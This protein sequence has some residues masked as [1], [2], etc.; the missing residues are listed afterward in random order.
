[1]GIVIR[2][3]LK[4]TF[5]N[6][7]GVILGI[8]IQFY[9]V[10]KYLEPQVYG[11]TQ[12]IYQAA[13]LFATFALLGSGSSGMRYF[14]YFRDEKTRD[15][16]FLYYFMM[17]PALGC[18]IFVPLYIVLKPAIA[19]Y[20]AT[21][22]PEFVDYYYYVIPFIV[23]LCFWFW[24]ENYANINMRIAIPKTVREILMRLLMLGCY[25]AYG[26]GYLDVQ[27][28]ILSFA[29][30][31]A[32]C[33]L[34][35]GSYALKIGSSTT[36]HRD[37][38]VLTPEVKRDFLNYTFIVLI[39]SLVNVVYQL[40]IFMLSGEKGLYDAGIYS[41]MIFFAN[42]VNMPA[43]SITA[44][45]APG[46]A[47]AM[48]RNDTATASALFKQVS[49]HQLMA[50]AITLLVIWI[51][52]DNIFEIMP[53]GDKFSAGRYAM[54]LLG[55]SQ[56]VYCTLNFGG[57]IISYSKYYYWTLFVTVLLI[58]LTITTNKIFIPMWGLAGA[59]FATLL[60][61][62]I[63]YS[64]QQVIIQFKI[65]ANPFTWSHLRLLLIIG[66]L[67]G[68]NF[69]IPSFREVSPWLDILVR[70]AAMGLG[71]VLLLYAF[72]VSVQVNGIID[73]YIL[74]KGR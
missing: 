69:L 55:L 46:V 15:H 41:M 73:Y 40:D 57:S 1:M 17:L 58:F 38:S 59:A 53:N 21:K 25:L 56:V 54:L 24:T 52:L 31:Y 13:V 3:S 35:T 47:D 64:W 50:G 44:I 5:V 12:V 10:A 66:F 74:R 33:L 63:S 16:G 30:S 49:V 37:L 42:V 19:A 20:F 4:S 14:P 27:G 6:Y 72:K 22:S 7:I 67:Y 34:C 23:I 29:A 45:S 32:I 71:Y 43:R 26:F 8:P 65:H 36:R 61:N 9:V 11:L 39:G 28:L 60:T 70:T 18:L 2:Q 51:N 48:K 62:L 68:L